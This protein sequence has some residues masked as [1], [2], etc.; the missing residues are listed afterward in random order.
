MRYLIIIL[1]TLFSFSYKAQDA[2]TLVPYLVNISN[3]IRS[4]NAAELTEMGKTGA[5]LA[6]VVE[7]G[8]NIQ[9][10]YGVIQDLESV[11]KLYDLYNQYICVATDFEI[12]LAMNGNINDCVLQ[13]NMD[14]ALLKFSASKE[15]MAGL[16]LLNAAQKFNMDQASQ[17][18]LFKQCVD[19]LEQSFNELHQLNGQ[20]R[21]RFKLMV[22]KE[23]GIDDFGEDGNQN[24]DILIDTTIKYKEIPDIA[25]VPGPNGNS[26]S[27]IDQTVAVLKQ[28]TAENEAIVGDDLVDKQMDKAKEKSE[29]GKKDDLRFIVLDW[30]VY[31]GTFLAF[32]YVILG[33]ATGANNKSTRFISFIVG[34]VLVS[35]YIY[36]RN[37]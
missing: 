13:F 7:Q 28:K 31:L 12:L 26:Q 10:L 3:A 18:S 11:K 24:A 33:F 34:L 2:Q 19:L 1:L 6:Q 21:L 8:K 20:L 27:A 9:K 23:Y 35:I 29:L 5:F 37:Y 30:I 4:G 16:G 15:I 25:I 22:E 14:K 32:I 17:I 36:F